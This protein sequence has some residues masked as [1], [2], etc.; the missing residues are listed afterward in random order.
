MDVNK[1]ILI[2][3][4]SFLIFWK[5]WLAKISV[6]ASQTL[7]YLLC[8]DTITAIAAT[9]VF[10]E[11]TSPSNN[12]FIGVNFVKSHII[13]QA[14]FRWAFVNLKCNVSENFLSSFLLIFILGAIS[15]FNSFFIFNIRKLAKNN[16][17]KANLFLAC[18]MSEASFG[19]WIF[20]IASFSEIR[21]SCLITPCGRKSSI[22]LSTL[23]IIGFRIFLKYLLVKP[24]VS[25]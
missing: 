2:F 19:K 11:P 8:D 21:F 3:G 22:K 20:F 14:V 4:R 18:S 10:P 16:S 25:G 15:S 23:K 6:G 12:L 7:W 17:S 9:T 5:C 24:S 13:S 1:P